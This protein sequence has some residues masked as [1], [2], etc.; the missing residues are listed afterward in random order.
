MGTVPL[1]TGLCLRI[2][3]LF[4]KSLPLTVSADWQ[5]LALYVAHILIGMGTLDELGVLVVR[6]FRPRLR[7]R[8]AS[9]F[10]PRYT[11]RPGPG[12]SAGAH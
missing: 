5:T 9:F 4:K 7:R 12:F 10:C 11:L 6:A 1:V 2:A 3:E 8:W